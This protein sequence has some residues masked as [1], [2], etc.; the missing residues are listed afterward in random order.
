MEGETETEKERETERVKEGDRKRERPN[1]IR[2]TS[3]LMQTNYSP[4]QG[5]SLP[6]RKAAACALGE[7]MLIL[8]LILK[9][10]GQSI[11]LI[12]LRNREI[13][14]FLKAKQVACGMRVWAPLIPGALREWLELRQEN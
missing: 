13:N 3:P 12:S 11:A 1:S 14:M 5:Q 9:G 4:A 6:E 7:E 8:G 10:P 2:N